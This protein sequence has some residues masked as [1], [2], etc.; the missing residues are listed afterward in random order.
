MPQTSWRVTL[1]GPRRAVK[2]CLLWR[3]RI[4]KWGLKTHS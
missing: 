1:V 2:L 3:R 4:L